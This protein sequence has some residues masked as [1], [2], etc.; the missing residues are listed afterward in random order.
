M[1]NI[2]GPSQWKRRLLSSVVESQLLYATPVWINSVSASARS[3]ANLIRPQK[4]AAL[5]V[6]R[7][8]RTVSDEASL[9]LA[10]M[11]P[12]DLLG[13]KILKIRVRTHALALPGDPT[14]LSKDAIKSEERRITV[15]Q[16][17]VTLSSTT[18]ALWTRLAFPDIVRW[19]GRT[20]P[21]VPLSYHMTQAL[22]AHGCFSITYIGWVGLTA[23][24]AITATV[25]Q[26]PLTTPFLS[27][28]VGAI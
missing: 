7:A 21:E 19:L 26:T 20:F 23:R 16:W 14:P 17:Q 8:Y 13:K 11:P 12:A 25:T 27:A 3:R 2:S 9:L 10:A 4:S 22:T 24:A 1:P 6:I 5:R 18:K 28:S 15:A